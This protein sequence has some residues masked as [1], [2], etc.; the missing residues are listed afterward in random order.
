MR[1]G[2]ETEHKLFFGTSRGKIVVQKE[3]TE[4]IREVYIPDVFNEDMLDN[5]FSEMILE[6][7]DAYSK[8]NESNSHPELRSRLTL[9]Y[10]SEYRQLKKN[11]EDATRRI[12]S[13]NHKNHKNHQEQ[14]YE[15]N[16]LRKKNLTHL[17]KTREDSY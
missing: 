7:M 5:H 14:K 6:S 11:W 13:P 12:M 9:K 16:P 1:T 2:K 15:N 3:A 10:P 4:N 8:G 17:F